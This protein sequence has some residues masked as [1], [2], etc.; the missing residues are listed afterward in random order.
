MKRKNAMPDANSI[1]QKMIG[2]SLLRN[3]NK[4]NL[5]K[6]AEGEQVL[7]IAK[8]YEPIA[9]MIPYNLYLKWQDFIMA[10]MPRRSDAG[11]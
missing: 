3:M 10:T 8:G 1:G 6:F 5:R 4:R 7:V 9:A 2:V 11:R